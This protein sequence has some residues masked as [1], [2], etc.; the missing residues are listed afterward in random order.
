M[1][2]HDNNQS[3]GRGNRPIETLRDGA[4]KISIFRNRGEQGDS[5][6]VLPS[7]IYTD[8]ETG[9]VRETTSLAG[10][11][12]LRMAHLLTKSHE[13]IAEFRNEMKQARST[14]RAPERNELPRDRSRNRNDRSRER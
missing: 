4:L 5:Y 14:E 3:R 7:R 9:E 12:P 1:N 10:S 8:K 2:E 13:R 11:E 6:A